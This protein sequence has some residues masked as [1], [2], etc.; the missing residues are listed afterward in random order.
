MATLNRIVE[1]S[2]KNE[3][4][5]RET[6]QQ[7]LK[8]INKLNSSFSKQFEVF[9]FKFTKDAEMEMDTDLRNG[10][11]QKISK[12]VKSRKRGEPIR[13]LYDSL[14]PKDLLKRL[15]QKLNV[16]KLDTILPSG[17]YHN[18]KDFM[19]FPDCGRKE[20][21]YLAWPSIHKRE[22]QEGSMLSLVRQRDRF[23]HVPYHS[24]DAY[25]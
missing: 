15:M 17:R 13:V 18:H 19:K 5:E 2:D 25:I 21:R 12:G 14:M 20:L 24:F 22:F 10:L 23:I 11:M 6:A 16:D 9:S 7:T 1:Y 4:R 3:K 8:Q